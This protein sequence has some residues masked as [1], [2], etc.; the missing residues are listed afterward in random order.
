MWMASATPETLNTRCGSQTHEIRA[1]H[2]R[3]K[4]QDYLR[5]PWQHAL[6]SIQA[7]ATCILDLL[8]FGTALAYNG[9]HAR[10][11]NHEFDGD[12]PAA[13]DRRF[14]EWLVVDPAY[15]ETEGL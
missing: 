10:V 4:A 11:G 8:D 3:R 14:V 9:S 1:V 6:A 13:W 12:C 2:M 15:D 7:C 5:R